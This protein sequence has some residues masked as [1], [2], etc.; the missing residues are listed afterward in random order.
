MTSSR[1]LHALGFA[2][3]DRPWEANLTALLHLLSQA[4][5]DSFTL[6]P[7]LCLTGYSYE[8]MKEAAAFSEKALKRLQDATADKSLGLTCIVC[9]PT[10]FVNRFFWL[11]NGR[12]CYTQDKAKLFPLGNEPAHFE[13]GEETAIVPFTCKDVRLGVLVCFELRFPFLWEQ[14]KGVD[15]ILVPALWG[16]GRKGHFETLCEALAIA[17]QCY[18]IASNSTDTTMAGGSAIID[19]FG[20]TLRDDNAPLLTCNALPKTLSAMRRYITIGL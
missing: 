11:S 1:L 13:A 3:Q 9:T 16:K 2:Y 4:K 18:V 12:I 8:R 7:E 14:L 5:P 20:V 15:I 19:P 6:A 10:G 17:N